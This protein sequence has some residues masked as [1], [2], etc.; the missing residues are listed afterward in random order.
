MLTPL[1]KAHGFEFI[2]TKKSP[3]TFIKIKFTKRDLQGNYT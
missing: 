1:P 3:Q 2:R